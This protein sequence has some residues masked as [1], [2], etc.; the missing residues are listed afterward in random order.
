MDYIIKRVGDDNLYLMHYGVPGMKW[1]HR[2]AQLSTSSTRSRYDSTKAAYKNAKKDFSK[3]YD[4]ALSYSAR[5]LIGQYTNK[6]KKAESNKRWN[7]AY[8][9]AKASDKAR[10]DYENAKA[11]RKDKI[12]KTYSDIQKK[13]SFGEKLIYNNATRKR[14][15]KYVVDNGMSVKEAKSRANKDAIRNTG[16]V[17][18]AYG[19]VMAATLYKMK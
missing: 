4:K 13:T 9:K 15:A 14:A 10:S 6:N 7:D 2:K 5:H 17:L 8:D 16:I 1:G 3:A 12:N 11:Q 19:G 18:A